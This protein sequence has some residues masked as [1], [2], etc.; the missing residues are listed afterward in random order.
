MTHK[1]EHTIPVH[2]EPEPWH[3][4]SPEEGEPQEE[5]AGAVNTTILLGVFVATVVFVFASILFTY[6]Y[7]TRYMTDLRQEQVETTVIGDDFRDYQ[8][9]SAAALGEYGWVDPAAGIVS[10]PLDVAKTRVLE[11]YA[12]K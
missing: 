3:R 10:I 11:R 7:F 1:L 6:L 9:R 5:H 12:G 4:H 2:E 8:S